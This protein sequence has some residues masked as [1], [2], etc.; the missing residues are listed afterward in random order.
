VIARIQIK[1]EIGRA[2]VSLLFSIRFLLL[3]DC[4]LPHGL[5][6][7]IYV[8]DGSPSWQGGWQDKGRWPTHN[9]LQHA[10]ELRTHPLTRDHPLFKIFQRIKRDKRLPHRVTNIR[11]VFF[12]LCIWLGLL[13]VSESFCRP[14]DRS[15]ARAS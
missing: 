14:I 8:L 7:S 11:M 6:I 3:G 4:I 2:A 15:I 12:R 13:Y 9:C 5:D 10:S 1:R